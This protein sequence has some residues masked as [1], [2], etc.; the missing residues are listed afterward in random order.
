[1]IHRTQVLLAVVPAFV[2]ACG[3]EAPAEDGGGPHGEDGVAEASGVFEVV[4][5]GGTP[6]TLRP[7]PSPPA[8]GD[9]RFVIDLPDDLPDSLEVSIDLVSPE[10]PMMGIR[11]YPA[12]RAGDGTWVADARIMMAGLWDVYVNLGFGADAAEFEFQVEA[13][14]GA[15]AH[16][17]GGR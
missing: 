2:L 13:A 15:P 12:V 1:M 7:D 8:V 10:M 17:H 6:V 14:D 3:G 9:V 4:S 5:T 16:Q 11:R